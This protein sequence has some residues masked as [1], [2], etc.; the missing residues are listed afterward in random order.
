MAIIDLRTSRHRIAGATLESDEDRDAHRR[1]GLPRIE[2]G[3]PRR[4]AVGDLPWRRGGRDH[5]RLPRAR[6]TRLHGPRHE[7]GLGD[8]AARRDDPADLELRALDRGRGRARRRGLRARRAG[9]G[10]RDRRRAHDGDHPPA[11]RG[12]G[13]AADRG[14]EDDRQRHRRH[15]LHLRLRHCGPHRQRSDRPSPHDRPVP[16]PRS[17]R[18]GDGPERRLDRPARRDRRR[19]RRDRDSRGRH[20]LRGDRGFRSRRATITARTSRSWSSPRAQT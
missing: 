18:R 4:H 13:P 3:D 7:D 16:R 20:D 8:P 17:G 2:R 6:R 14:A 9:R 5:A 12:R 11:P 1:W 15:R 10:R 19:R